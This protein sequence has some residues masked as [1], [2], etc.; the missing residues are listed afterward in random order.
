M[1]EWLSQIDLYVCVCGGGVMIYGTQGE[2]KKVTRNYIFKYL[3]RRT[4]NEV[5]KRK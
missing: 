3:A 4:K 2:R 1:S 5:F